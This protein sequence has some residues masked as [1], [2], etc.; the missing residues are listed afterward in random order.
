[1]GRVKTDFP[2]SA[3]QVVSVDERVFGLSRHFATKKWA[4]WVGNFGLSEG[5]LR[6]TS[7]LRKSALRPLRNLFWPSSQVPHAG[8]ITGSPRDPPRPST[9]QRSAWRRGEFS[10]PR[11]HLT[12]KMVA[13]DAEGFTEG[14]QSRFSR[15]PAGSRGHRGAHVA[16]EHGGQEEPSM[17]FIFR[18]VL[19]STTI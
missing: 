19:I 10:R 9:A 15:D 8:D 5:D 11:R 18:E 6:S 14:D 16:H 3:R 2:E 17:Y 13:N 12:P 7:H 4:R 1:M